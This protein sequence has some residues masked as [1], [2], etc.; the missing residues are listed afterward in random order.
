MRIGNFTHFYIRAGL[1]NVNNIILDFDGVIADSEYF[2]L[3][4]WEGLLKERN[5]PVNNLKLKAIAG[6]SDFLAISNLCPGLEEGDYKDLVDEKKKRFN[7]KIDMLKPVSGIDRIFKLFLNRKAFFICSNSSRELIDFFMAKHFPFVRINVI[8]SKGDFKNR[9][10][11][12]EPYHVLL[13]RARINA[14]QAV[15]IEDSAAG[16]HSASGVG[17]NVIY[18]NRYDIHIADV[19]QIKSLKEFEMADRY[20][21]DSYERA[22]L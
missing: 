19:P 17:L 12:S 11:D 13:R 10:P 8:V 1:K 14:P 2:Q 21:I 22:Q 9:K 7:D 16:I 18:L 6:I 20:W 4:I 15:V 5:L 3:D